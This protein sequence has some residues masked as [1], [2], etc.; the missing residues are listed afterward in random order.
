MSK[1]GGDLAA[2]ERYRRASERATDQ[3]IRHYS[4]SFGAATRL[5]GSRHR[6]HVRN[7]Y[8]LVR[9]ADELVD[10][11]AEAA[12]LSPQEQR[13]RLDELE[14][15]T[16]EALM[17]GYSSNPIV[18]AFAVTARAA[19][20]SGSLTQPFFA[21]MRMDLADTSATGQHTD[22]HPAAIKHF[23]VRTHA[24]YVYGSAEVVGLMCLR[25]FTRD[26]HLS[27]DEVSTLEHGARSLGAAF[28]NVNF[29]RDLAD[30]TERLGRSY[31]SDTSAFT[32]SD[33]ERWVQTIRT[34]LAEA[35]ASMPL[36]PSDARLAVDCAHRLF[37]CLNEKLAAI[38]VEELMTRR[39]RVSNP[40]KVALI[41]RSFS[42]TLRMKTK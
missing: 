21:S 2:F 16:E 24:D 35:R 12:K 7:I 3:I 23:D 9:I 30:D 15:E 29:L 5:L 18:Q 40:K 1:H 10:G 41:A 33:K 34:Q 8:G 26:Q 17:S 38:P 36:L 22:A 19:G 27:P 42:E 11:V 39:V 6:Q 13:A 37:A 4:T 25:V 14:R 28:Q 31:L 32:S 20:I